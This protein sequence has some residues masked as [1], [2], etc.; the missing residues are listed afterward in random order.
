MLNCSPRLRLW[1]TAAAALIGYASAAAMLTWPLAPNA[2]TALLGDPTGDTGVYVWNLW[3][4]GHEL[5]NHGHLP[6]STSHVF[7]YTGGVDFSLHNYTPLAG[8]VGMLL[9]PWAGVVGGFNLVLLAFI[10]L[11]GLGM[12]VLGRQVGLRTTS[13]FV[14]GLLFIAAP[15]V[16]AKATAHASLVAAFPLPLFLWALLRTIE[17]PRLHSGVLVGLLVAT[18]TYADA[19]YG[20]YCLIMG[21]FVL[22]WRF[23]HLDPRGRAAP[24]WRAIHGID[25]VCLIVAA[26]VVWRIVSGTTALFIGP[27]RVGMRTLYTPMLA[28]VVLGGLRAWLTWR[29]RLRLDDPEARLPSLI[30]AGVVAVATCLALL[31]PLL[32]GLA[33]RYAEGRWPDTVTY[34]RSS[35]RGVDLLAY[36][37]PNPTH[38]WFGRWTQHW[39]L[40]DVGD[41]FP[42]FVASFSLV[43]F[44]AIAVTAWRR[45]LPRMWVA[46]SA[47]FVLL[48][49]GPFVH[50]GGVNTFV[51]GPWSVLRY[52]PIIGMARSPS[53]FAIVA[54]IGLSL[55]FAFAVD[56]WLARRRRSSWPLTP[57]LIGCLIAWEVFPAPRRLYSAEVPDVYRMIAGGNDEQG[58]LLELPAGIRDGV[59]SI[60]DFNASTMFF[61]TKH[62]RPLIGGY[63]SRVSER[64]KRENLRMPMLRA[65]YTLSERPGPLPTDLL[66]AALGA[67]E[68]FLTRACIKYVVVDKAR[69]SSDLRAFA[70][71][72]L[73]LVPLHEDER[74]ELLTV[75]QPPTCEHRVEAAREWARRGPDQ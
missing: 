5:V 42:E 74:Y 48:S 36:L 30:R 3:I 13:A 50:V 10:A 59:S 55:L 51:V 35:P 40:P 66:N 12:F 16:T 38:P 56:A 18:A 21:L 68:R 67:R 63:L 65:L 9:V 29:P 26:V 11:S 28:L 62:E 33:N 69:A 72:A 41:A 53:R 60:G 70:S 61:Q 43:A 45:V 8:L 34:W 71:E 49:L 1:L 25:V 20:V 39:L 19:Y 44:A 15:L 24:P 14:A 31:S 23:L 57:A 27:F 47:L 22:A 37:V 6:V 46:F 17:R 7:S 54:A 75:A 52:I 58:R 4:F 64:R 2:T 73:G 32:V